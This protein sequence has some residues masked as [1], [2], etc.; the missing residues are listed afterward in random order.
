MLTSSPAFCPSQTCSVSNFKTIQLNPGLSAYLAKV[1]TEHLAAI[2]K[3]KLSNLRYTRILN[4]PIP[5]NLVIYRG[6]QSDQPHLDAIAKAIRKRRQEQ[7][8]QP[9][10]EALMRSGVADDG[11]LLP[12]DAEQKSDGGKG[13]SKAGPAATVWRGAKPKRTYPEQRAQP[14]RYYCGERFLTA[15]GR[16]KLEF[17]DKPLTS[18][19]HSPAVPATCVMALAPE[20]EG[21]VPKTANIVF[22]PQADF[23]E[24]FL[25]G[26]T[27]CGADFVEP[28]NGVPATTDITSPEDINRALTI[29]GAV[30]Q[31]ARLGQLN[32]YF[33]VSSPEQDEK[34]SDRTSSSGSSSA[35]AAAT[36][37][38]A[39]PS[40]KTDSKSRPGVFSRMFSYFSGSSSAASDAS[41]S[42]KTPKSN[43]K[44]DDDHRDQLRSDMRAAERIGRTY[45]RSAN[46]AEILA[47]Q[48]RFRAR[49]KAGEPVIR[50][51]PVREGFPQGMP[52]PQS[53][54]ARHYG[55][56]IVSHSIF[57]EPTPPI[58][59]TFSSTQSTFVSEI[60]WTQQFYATSNTPLRDILQSFAPPG[61]FIPFN[62]TAPWAAPNGLGGGNLGGV[63]NTSL[64]RQVS[65]ERFLDNEEPLEQS[66]PEYKM[67]HTA[68][69]KTVNANEHCITRISRVINEDLGELYLTKKRIMEKYGDPNETIAF[70]GTNKASLEQIK[71]A[72]FNRT[73]AGV[74]GTAYG[75][76]T[77]FAR[78][79]SYSVGYA[80]QDSNRKFYMFAA[81]ILRGNPG[82]AESSLKGNPLKTSSPGSPMSYISS[83]MS[84]ASAKPTSPASPV[85]ESPEGKSPTPSKPKSPL[86]FEYFDR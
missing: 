44:R 70:H 63:G 52:D 15:W 13:G 50:Y 20:L 73:F 32:D 38:G 45:D 33:P 42:A 46:A 60:N 72:G 77:Y 17:W 71:I 85:P 47:V 31:A 54:G 82:Q 24:I 76:G 61:A 36:A 59:S 22:H 80:R 23:A 11:S 83:A 29:S 55:L 58:A 51:P 86:P 9:S 7:F 66:S 4:S 40:G 28:C 12:G 37:A 34:G 5:R 25:I 75:K 57:D 48:A 16:F 1:K 39:S 68:F 69:Y 2:R 79:A 67:I 43:S 35:A 49:I 14:S 10:Y 84:S 3:G 53:Y 41:S 56:E 26:D 30:S 21:I 74:N 62:R 65:I 6:R 81:Q 78:D 27:K 18:E 19:R 64:Q 8:K